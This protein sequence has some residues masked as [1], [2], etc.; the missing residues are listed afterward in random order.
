M[1][2]TVAQPAA[3]APATAM[4]VLGI[5]NL[6][7]ADEGFGVRAVEALHRR[8]VFPSNVSLVDGG[9]QGMYLLDHVCAADRVLVFDAIDYRLPPGTLR[10]FR[11]EE[12]PV[13]SDRM[14]SLHQATFQELLSLAHLRGRYPSRITLIGV[15][16]DVLDDLGGSLSPLVRARLDEAV[17]LAVAELARWGVAATPRIEPPAEPLS[18]GALALE[19]YEAERPSEA[20]ACRVGD[21][22]VLEQFRLK[23]AG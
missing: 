6:L 12:V 5:G 7:W 4:L 9:T 23:V 13:W 14:M 1:R 15:Q 16:P 20:A 3:A 21:A 8:Y 22:R 17:A 11:D 18:P 2:T 19:A 10:V